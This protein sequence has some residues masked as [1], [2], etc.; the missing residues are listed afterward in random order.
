MFLKETY[1]PVLL[2][3]KAAKIRNQSGV[4]RNEIRSK[5]DSGR[6]PHQLFMTAIIS[7]SKMLA[8][9]P[10][11]SVLAVYLGLV[12]SYMYLLYTSFTPVFQTQYGFST[13]AAGLAFLGLGIGFVL[14]QL[15]V[16]LFADRYL[17]YQAKHSSDGKTKPEDRL[18]PLF[19]GSLLIPAG[20]VWYGWSAE[21]QT[22]WI[23]PILGTTIVG[24]GC[25]LDFLSMQM[26]LVDTFGIYAATATATN[27]IVRSLFGALIPLAESSLYD[28]LG[29]GWRN[30]TLAFIALAF[31]VVPLGLMRFGERVGLDPRFQ[32]RL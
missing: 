31:V 13:G 10:V 7:P 5:Y 29:Y 24:I 11:V 14:G 18:P 22:Q 32:L 27:T 15:F 23:V 28:R 4:S 3:R 30:T 16:G 2:E 19:A 8:L 1:A 25:V 20:L 6:S 21:Y 12:Y 26:Y 17:R 9:S